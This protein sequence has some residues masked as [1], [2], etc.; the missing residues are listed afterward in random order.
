MST[1]ARVLCL[2]LCLSLLLAASASAVL[3]YRVGVQGPYD[4]SKAYEVLDQLNAYRAENGLAPLTMDAEL[5]EAA[6]QRAAEISIHFDHTR[7]DGSMCYT[8]SPK[9]YAENIAAGQNT[10]ALVMSDWKNSPGHNAAM[11]NESYQSV[12]IGCAYINGRW[13]WVQCF[14]QGAGTPESVPTSGSL[15]RD[16]IAVTAAREGSYDGVSWSFDYD[17]LT[18]TVTGT[19]IV[20]T[21]LMDNWAVFATTVVV[22]EGITAIDA[23]TFGSF[24]ALQRVE[25]PSTLRSVGTYAFSGCYNLA[26]VSYNGPA[27]DWAAVTVSGGNTRLTSAALQTTEPVHEHEWDEGVETQALTCTQDGIVT[28]TCACGETRTETTPAPGHAWGEWETIKEASCL[29]SGSRK[30]VCG[31]CGLEQTET[32][33]KLGHD[34]SEW[35]ITQAPTCTEA[36]QETRSCS[37]DVA[38][39]VRPVAALGHDYVNGICTRCDAR[40]PDYVPTPGT[41]TPG[42]INGDGRVS[43]RDLTRLAQYLAG[44]VV[45]YVPGSLDVNG[46]GKVNNR[47][48]T[49]L[50]QYRAG[51][52][53]ELY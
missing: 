24:Q 10:V 26:E 51:K 31:R 17:T 38:V 25:L 6:M 4:Y 18:L 41:H 7:P 45:Q 29:F 12:G 37:R 3:C 50:A 42:D 5:L 15:Y 27:A 34:W 49:R 19:G 16:D 1:K 43:N 23:E 39:Q 13:N 21:D 46:D 53:V 8:A 9:M 11:L 14:G 48:L 30:H 33:P 22:G 44:K 28:Y 2:F 40:D 52:S 47:D 35:E 32:L 20:S 36:G